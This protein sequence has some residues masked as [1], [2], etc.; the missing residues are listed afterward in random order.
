M[1]RHVRARGN[2][3]TLTD[4]ARGIESGGAR[5]TGE[6]GADRWDLASRERRARAR[7]WGKLGRLGQKG[8][9][10]G[11]LAALTFLFKSEFLIPF[12]F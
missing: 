6:V 4:Q 2:D 8:E 3:T 1:Q 9:G 10:E 11:I 12:L 5:A 7:A